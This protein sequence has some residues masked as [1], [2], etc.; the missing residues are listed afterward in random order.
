MPQPCHQIRV[1]DRRSG[2][3]SEHRFTA[4]CVR[5]GRDPA[6]ELHLPDPFVSAQHALLE[7]D[8]RGA[9]LRYLGGTNGLRV[10]GRRLAPHTAVPFDAR[11]RVSLGPFDLD[12]IHTQGRDRRAAHGALDEVGPDKLDQLH[13]RLRQLRALHTPFVAARHAF[14]AALADAL[15]TTDDPAN[16]RRLLAE[17]PPE[18]HAHLVLPDLSTPRP[19]PDAPP[20][21]LSQGP[22]SI[23]MSQ[24]PAS[25]ALSQGPASVARPPVPT[26]PTTAPTGLQQIADAARDLLPLARPPASQGE[27]RRFLARL[28]D[29]TRDLAAGVT[30][31]QHLRRRQISELGITT[32]ADINPLL[33]I[34]DADELLGELLTRDDRRPELLDCFAVLTAHAH[35]H[36]AAALAAARHLAAELAPP[37]VVRHAAPGLLRTRARWRS[38]L[39]RHAA[40][41][42]DQHTPG[43]LRTSFRAAYLAEL[44]AHGP[45]A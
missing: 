26:R 29:V 41:L 17:F 36:T 25:V 28:V 12:I 32:S 35:A 9:Q 11:L 24:G 1:H 16:A 19:T 5:I 2:V 30:A 10:A 20:Q 14:E 37:V 6:C 18:D 3:T 8:E 4:T 40:C 34:T 7:A 33:G 23:D 44:D 13:A 21:N 42:G 45:P 43:S 31:L 22:A 27:A 38:Y 15:H 39:D